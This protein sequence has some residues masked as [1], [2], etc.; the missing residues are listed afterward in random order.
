MD[1][2]KDDGIDGRKNRTSK[3]Y[4]KKKRN[5]EPQTFKKIRE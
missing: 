2:G 4:W 3:L 1:E 5:Q